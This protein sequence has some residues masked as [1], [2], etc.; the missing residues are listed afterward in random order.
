MCSVFVGRGTHVRVRGGACMH[1][2]W[3]MYMCGVGH[4]CVWGGACMR[5]GWGMY[6][7]VCVIKD[8]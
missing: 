5:V 2:G 8:L 7:C 3:G 1:E 6:L 4:V